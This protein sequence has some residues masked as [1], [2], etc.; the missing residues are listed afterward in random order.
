MSGSLRAGADLSIMNFE[1]QPKQVSLMRSVPMRRTTLTAVLAVLALA[2]S[3]PFGCGGDDTASSGP[4]ENAPFADAGTEQEEDASTNN[5]EEI[6]YPDVDVPRVPTSVETS[7]VQSF[8]KAGEAAIVDCLVLDQDG[9]TIV[10]PDVEFD[11]AYGPEGTFIEE[12]DGTWI[13]VRAGE[14]TVRCAVPDLALVDPTPEVITIEPG[15]AHSTQLTTDETSIVAGGTVSGECSVWDAYGNEIEGV[16]KELI[17]S[18]DQT[19]TQ[20][21]LLEATFETAGIYELSCRVSGIA[22][23]Q[24]VSLEVVPGLPANINIDKFPSQNVYAVGQVVTISTVVSDQYGNV[25][26]NPSLIHTIDPAALSFG[27]ARY[28]FDTEG[29]Y[30]ATVDVDGPTFQGIN[31]TRSIEIVVNSEGP[32]VVCDSPVNGAMLRQSPGTSIVLTGSV[33]D[34][35]GVQSV[36]VNGTGASIDAN[37][38]F[39]AAVTTQFG[40]NFVEVIARDDLGEENSTTCAFMVAPTYRSEGSFISDSVMLKMRQPAVDDNNTSDTDSLNDLLDAVVNSPALVQQLKDGITANG[41]RLYNNCEARVLGVCVTRVT[42]DY[43]NLVI[44]GP[45]TSSLRLVQD[46]LRAVA[47]IRDIGLRV[48][49]SGQLLGIPYDTTGWIDLSYV[50]MDL[51]MDLEERLGRPSASVR[52]INSISVGNVSTREF[53]GLDGGIISIAIS[54]FEGT[55]KNLIRDTIRDFIRNNFNQLLDDVFSN[56]DIDSLGSSIGVPRLDGSGNISLNFGVRFNSLSVNTARAL[57]GLGT[58]F[59]TT[60]AHGRASLGVPLQGTAP[61]IDPSTA[62]PLAVAVYLGV[63]NHA[64]HALWRGGFFDATLSGSSVGSFPAGVEAT[65]QTDL[66]PVLENLSNGDA[67]LS[68]GAMRLNLVYPGIFDDG[69]DVVLGATGQ[70]SV[71]IQGDELAFGSINITDLSFST[72]SVSLDASTRAV[73]ENFLR[74]LLQ[75]II[76]DALNNALPALP[77]PGFDLPTSVTNYG[78]PANS[79]LSIVNPS[80]NV[81]LSHYLLTGSFGFR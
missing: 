32:D 54:V 14:G 39:S 25:I 4:E 35:N 2:L 41:T 47:T 57:F 58:R 22:E 76:D 49:I 52:Q 36:T 70:T 11:I 55:I 30:L 53:G 50:S 17:V 19:T 81:T 27:D 40:I 37:G 20:V 79:E 23:A 31:L 29:V 16:S 56:L 64:L 9:Q 80:L 51:T 10:E 71:A 33:A 7:V 72:T 74:T 75:S 65:L 28:R 34:A 66:P 63:F 5:V 48:R 26:E 67:R 69:I 44:G 8:I 15:P 42:I 46:G 73:L 21:T 77:I 60:P 24:G 1:L 18:P 78:L 45:N 38:T 61:Y 13:G 59:T 68:L 12:M 3:G 43:R 6:E 62:R